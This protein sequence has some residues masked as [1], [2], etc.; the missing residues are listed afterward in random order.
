MLFEG[1]HWL[2]WLFTYCFSFLAYVE[3]DI[4]SGVF[5][6]MALEFIILPNG[7]RKLIFEDYIFVM[8][9][10]LTDGA[11]SWECSKR[12][13]AQS[14]WAKVKTDNDIFVGRTNDHTCS[15]FP[16]LADVGVLKACIAMTTQAQ[17]SDDRTQAIIGANTHQLSEEERA[18]LPSLE[19]M[20][21]SIRRAREVDNPPVP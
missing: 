8:Q 21:Q 3:V 17:T 6:D 15:A 20:R 19:T 9:K 7:K 11:I 16:N 12:R 18:N 14:C 1:G 2:M 4:S 13:N 5:T 10:E